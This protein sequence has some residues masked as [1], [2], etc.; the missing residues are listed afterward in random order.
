MED[1][2]TRPLIDTSLSERC[3]GISHRTCNFC[4]GRLLYFRFIKPTL[5]RVFGVRFLGV[6]SLKL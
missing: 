5:S 3:V 4:F 6:F 2:E 1:V